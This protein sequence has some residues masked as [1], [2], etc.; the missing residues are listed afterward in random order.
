MLRL[1]RRAVPLHLFV[2]VGSWSR[3]DLR[4]SRNSSNL[5]HSCCADVERL[6]ASRAESQLKPRQE[7]VERGLR[8]CLLPA[9]QPRPGR[10]WCRLF[11]VLDVLPCTESK[12][13]NSSECLAYMEG[14]CG[15]FEVRDEVR[16][17][18]RQTQEF[19]IKC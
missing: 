3:Q 5:E 15:L 4:L 11:L 2:S 16:L 17:P 18:F 9:G 10:G 8:C 12:A 1:S 7:Q 14:K 19:S 13:S 6:P